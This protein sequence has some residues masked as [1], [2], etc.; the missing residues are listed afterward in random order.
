M[1]YSSLIQ[2]HSSEEYIESTCIHRAI[3]YDSKRI[4][5][6]HALQALDIREFANPMTITV[7]SLWPVASYPLHAHT[8]AI[9]SVFTHANPNIDISHTRYKIYR[10]S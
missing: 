7:R 2:I 9:C 3:G 4:R 5:S 10:L 1:D 6:E 8:V